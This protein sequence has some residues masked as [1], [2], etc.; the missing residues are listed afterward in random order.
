MRNSFFSLGIFL[1]FELYKHTSNYL[2]EYFCQCNFF[3]NKCKFA[4]TASFLTNK[5]RFRER[6]SS[7]PHRQQVG[8]F[9]GLEP[10]FHG[11]ESTS[12]VARPHPAPPLSSAPVLQSRPSSWVQPAVKVQPGFKLR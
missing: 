5:L 12:H 1:L 11:C 6:E 3:V 2:E 4:K 9:V 8:V 10:W 7:A